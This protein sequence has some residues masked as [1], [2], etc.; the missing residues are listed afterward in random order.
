LHN[1]KSSRSAKALIQ[2]FIHQFN[3]QKVLQIEFAGQSFVDDL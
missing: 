2:P 1:I 3:A